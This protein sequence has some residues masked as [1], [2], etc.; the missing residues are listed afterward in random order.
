M[1]WMFLF[2]ALVAL[3]IYREPLAATPFSSL[4][5]GVWGGILFVVAGATFLTYL[6][7]PIGQHHLRPTVVSM[8]NYVQ[9][10][11][12]VVLSVLLGM[13]RLTPLK[14]LAA[15][16]VFVGV[17]MVTKSKRRTT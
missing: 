17:W 4:P 13:D 10:V 8:Y 2:A 6:C 16:F 11:V 3:V 14:A 12:T 5:I 7:V 1:K 15:L 9:P